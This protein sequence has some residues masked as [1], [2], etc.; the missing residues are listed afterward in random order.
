MTAASNRPAAGRPSEVTPHPDGS[1]V[2][3]A[4][5]PVGGQP[6]AH[7]DAAHPGPASYGRGVRAAS[8]LVLLLG[9]AGIVVAYLGGGGPGLRSV[10]LGAGLLAVSSAASALVSAQMFRVAPAATAP[11]LA[12]LYLVKVLVL[13]WLLLVPGEPAWLEPAP[14]L[15]AA[16]V[17]HVVASACFVDLTRRV[18]RRE[19]AL[20]PPPAREEPANPSGAPSHREDEPAH[21]AEETP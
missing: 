3:A 4:S 5:A 21:H 12:F 20:L 11:A 15:C 6:P 9:A 8:A 10:C 14:F 7:D 2:A 18:S 16:L 19:A 1:Q 13:G 17:V